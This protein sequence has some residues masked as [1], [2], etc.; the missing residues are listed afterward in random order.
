MHT[1][2]HPTDA[3]VRACMRVFCQVLL[4]F[5]F[6]HFFKL[7]NYSVLCLVRAYL[8][9]LG[10]PFSFSC[11]VANTLLQRNPLR[12]AFKSNAKIMSLI[13]PAQG[14]APAP[15]AGAGAGEEKADGGRPAAPTSPPPQL[16]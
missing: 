13:E 7:L 9:A 3:C 15:A 6:L 2:A 8:S 14:P 1:H 12:Q 5:F 11:L 4:F 16:H 10:H